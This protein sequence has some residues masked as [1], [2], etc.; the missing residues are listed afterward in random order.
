[1]ALFFGITQFTHHQTPAFYSVESDSGL[2]NPGIS[3]SSK[4]VE[5][6]LKTF[7]ESVAEECEYGCLDTVPGYVTMI[8]GYIDYPLPLCLTPEE[9]S[10]WY[11]VVEVY[12]GYHPECGMIEVWQKD[13]LVGLIYVDWTFLGDEGCCAPEYWL[14]TFSLEEGVECIDLDSNQYPI[15]DEN[16]EVLACSRTIPGKEVCFSG[17][18]CWAGCTQDSQRFMIISTHAI[19]VFI[20][21]ICV[22]CLMP[23]DLYVACATIE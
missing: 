7:G 14:A 18:S 8:D 2:A 10:D 16:C 13:E 4:A 23:L 1:M 12:G 5:S 22:P 21:T 20:S 17:Y 19:S 15:V 9:I 6:N 11:Y 3:L